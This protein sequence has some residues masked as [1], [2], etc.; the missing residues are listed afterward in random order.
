VYVSC[1]LLFFYQTDVRDVVN[2][3]IRSNESCLIKSI[4]LAILFVRN[5]LRI[6]DCKSSSIDVQK[7]HK[8]II[9]PLL[10]RTIEQ[11]IYGV[12]RP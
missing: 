3:D 11:S 5:S 9:A 6:V 4:F 2:M 8:I 1:W 12:L 10:T 7:E